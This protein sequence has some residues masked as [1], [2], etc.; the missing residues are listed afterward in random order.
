MSWLGSVRRVL[1]R[2]ASSAERR[3][4]ATTTPYHE[5]YRDDPISPIEKTPASARKSFPAATAPPRR[6][7]SDASF[8]RNRRGQQDWLEDEQD[9][10]WRRTAGDDWGAPEDIAISER[11]RARQEWRERGNLL[12]NINSGDRLPTPRTPISPDQLGVPPIFDRPCTPASEADWDV[13]AAVE[14][15]VVQVMFT[16]PKSKLRVVNADIDGSSIMSVPATTR[17]GG[18]DRTAVEPG[19]SG[20]PSRV[21]DLAGRFEQLNYNSSPRT[22]PRPSPA[23]SIK[24]MKVRQKGSAASLAAGQGQ[25]GGRGKGFGARKRSGGDGGE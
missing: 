11:E 3:S 23:G 5:P 13:E 1:T 12:V 25:M 14:R 10:P 2:S 17:D 16:V 8:W 9:S 24:S 7:A 22:S 19:S 18:D 21:K 15:R 20:S 4:L 6:A